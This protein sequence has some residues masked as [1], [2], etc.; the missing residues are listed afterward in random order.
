[1]E[2]HLA[3]VGAGGRFRLLPQQD[4][5]GL[6]L[7]HSLPDQ[8]VPDRRTGREQPF[9]PPRLAVVL[10][11]GQLDRLAL[12]RLPRAGTPKSPKTKRFK[13]CVKAGIPAGRPLPAV[14]RKYP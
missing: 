14:Y 3:L 11:Q 2:R 12:I 7:E 9:D 4:W 1:M 6:L 8:R 5:P 13:D 10:G